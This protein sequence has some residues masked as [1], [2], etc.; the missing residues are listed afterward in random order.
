M[1][2]PRRIHTNQKGN[3]ITDVFVL[4][5]Y[6]EIAEEKGDWTTAKEYHRKIISKRVNPK[7]RA[8][9]QAAQDE[10]SLGSEEDEVG[11][12]EF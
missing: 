9:L 1:I 7:R 11:K 12:F 4:Q 10:M 6:K 3:Q 2:L 8:A 5:A